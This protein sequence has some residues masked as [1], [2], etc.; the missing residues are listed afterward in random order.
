MDKELSASTIIVSPPNAVNTAPKIV[1][2]IASNITT[3]DVSHVF[4]SASCNV[5]NVNLLLASIRAP[6][7]PNAPASVEVASPINIDPNTAEI[8]KE[9]GNF[10]VQFNEPQIAVTPGQS[11]VFYNDEICLGGATINSSF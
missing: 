6:T 10:S 4:N 9:S 8:K 1:D 5:S 2:A 7:A 11:I 3:A